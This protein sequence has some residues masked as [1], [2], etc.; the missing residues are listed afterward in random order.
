VDN[1]GDAAGPKEAL[2]YAERLERLAINDSGAATILDT[3]G[4]VYRCNGE[5]ERAAA[6]LEEALALNRNNLAAYLHLGQVYRAMNR[7]V[8]ARKVFTDGLERAR[9]TGATESIRS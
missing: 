6:A 8:D 4:W 2:A 1:A 7:A 3:V 5:L 9:Q